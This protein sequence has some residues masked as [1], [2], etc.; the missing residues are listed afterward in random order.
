[1][2]FLNLTSDAAWTNASAHAAWA[3]AVPA[4]AQ[5]ACGDDCRRFASVAWLLAAFVVEDLTHQKADASER[6]TD[7]LSKV[8]PCVALNVALEWK[9]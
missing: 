9:F 1:M 4:V 8:V 7:L 3:M 5:I 6:R 2:G